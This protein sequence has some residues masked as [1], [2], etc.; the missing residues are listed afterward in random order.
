MSVG[1][2]ATALTVVFIVSLLILVAELLYVLCRRRQSTHNVFL[3][4]FC[5]K[6]KTRVEPA[7]APPQNPGGSSPEDAVIDVF[8]LLEANGRSR[9]LCTIKEDDREDVESIEI[10][11]TE[12][13]SLQECLESEAAAAEEERAVT[14]H[15]E[16]VDTKTVFS[17]PYDSPMFY[18]PVGSPSREGMCS[19]L[20]SPVTGKNGR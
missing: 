20:V 10:A 11:V 1:K 15:A 12:R 19:E 9:V 17:S 13:M 5:L 7:G 18:T 3:Y 2:L 16:V 6:S 4:S 14:V 8:K